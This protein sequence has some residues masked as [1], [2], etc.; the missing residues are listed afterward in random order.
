[1]RQLLLTALL[2]LLAIPAAWADEIFVGNKPF[3]GRSYGVGEEVRFSLL[4]LAKALELPANSTPEGW[5]LGSSKV[6]IHEEHGVVWVSLDDLPSDLIRVVRNKDFGTV[7]LYR[8]ETQAA[9]GPGSSW[10]GGALIFFGASWDPHTQS[11]MPT[12]DEIERSKMVQVVY[13]DVE[14]MESESY[15]EFDY[16]FEGDKIP[17][18]VILDEKGRKVHSFFG[19]QTYSEMLAT[20]KKYVK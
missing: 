1:M 2:V 18:F 14:D 7:D 5:F 16:L 17:Y 4:D 20:L 8:V 9:S 11:M 3:E 13:V 12:I 15:K 6:E 19:F 10:S